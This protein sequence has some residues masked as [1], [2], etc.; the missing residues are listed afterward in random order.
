MNSQYKIIR[1]TST[2]VVLRDIGDH[3]KHLTVT[4]DA[5]R[6]AQELLDDGIWTAGMRLLYYDSDN[7]L[8]EIVPVVDGGHVV[9]VSFGWP[10]LE[11]G[12]RG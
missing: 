6:V 10:V 4:N 2:R 12:E 11:D 7:E 8:T 1:R 3:R 5:E 9:A